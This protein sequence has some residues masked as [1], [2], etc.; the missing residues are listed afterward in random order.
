MFVCLPAALCPPAPSPQERRARPTSVCDLDGRKTE[1]GLP[2]P[3]RPGSRPSLTF[4]SMI[5]GV[6]RGRVQGGGRGSR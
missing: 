5:Y 6:G 2:S 4:C 1:V 3:L